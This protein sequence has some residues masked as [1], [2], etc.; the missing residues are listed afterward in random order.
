[1]SEHTAGPDPNLEQVKNGER[2]GAEDDFYTQLQ[3][4][5]R[6]LF[7][8][9]TTR[10]KGKAESHY[11]EGVQNGVL[12]YEMADNF[13]TALGDVFIAV[14]SDVAVDGQYLPDKKKASQYVKVWVYDHS[15]SRFE[16]TRGI[17]EGVVLEEFFPQD[18]GELPELTK[19]EGKQ[20]AA[21]IR[22]VTPEDLA[23][24][25]TDEEETAEED[26]DVSH[27]YAELDVENT[28]QSEFIP[29]RASP[30]TKLNY[31]VQHGSGYSMFSRYGDA[32][33]SACDML[34][35]KLAYERYD[36]SMNPERQQQ[37]LDVLDTAVLSTEFDVV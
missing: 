12:T 23:E 21:C 3:D 31:Y 8:Y 5:L 11:E 9:G 34:R 33:D 15:D 24:L 13:S 27:E 29:R 16:Y 17:S 6:L 28:L 35:R 22:L 26:L 1:M 25:A 20:A 37:V 36:S 10:H 7:E 18:I 30:A 32:W 14:Q 19:E 4:R 2:K